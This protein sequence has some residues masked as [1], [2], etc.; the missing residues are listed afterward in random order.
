VEF[1]LELLAQFVFELLVQLI[2]QV[3]FEAGLHVLAAPFR[4][5]QNP[6]VSALGYVVLGLMLGALTLWIVPAHVVKAPALRWANLLLS[7]VLAG[8][9]MSLIG[10]WR[11]NRGQFLLRMDRFSYGYLFAFSVAA[12]RFVWAD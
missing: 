8:I 4:R 3:L 11:A 9:C 5:Q 2:G 7:P 1:L 10:T 12:V 6:W